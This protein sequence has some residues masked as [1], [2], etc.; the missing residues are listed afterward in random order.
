MFS[1]LIRRYGYCHL[2][3]MGM[4]PIALGTRPAPYGK[5]QHSPY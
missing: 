3:C 5:R 2:R 4:L 1:L